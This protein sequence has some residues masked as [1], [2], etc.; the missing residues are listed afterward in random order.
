MPGPSELDP[1][2][3]GHGDPTGTT[4]LEGGAADHGEGRGLRSST[5][6]LG[7]RDEQRRL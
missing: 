5:D 3:E 4:Q 7:K 2:T 6:S 1:R